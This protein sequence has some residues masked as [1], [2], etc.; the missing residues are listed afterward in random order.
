MRIA[1][2]GD[3]V[4][5]PGRKIIEANLKKIRD[6]FEIDFV[7]ANGEN[8][9]HGFGINP[10]NAN[11]LFSYGIDVITGGNHSWDKKEIIP[12]LE[13]EPRILRPDNY[14]L[15]V[16][17]SGLYVAEI[18]K[19]KLAIL[20]IMGNYFMPLVK[21]AF[22]W[23]QQRVQELKNSG[24]NS[25][26]I[27]F[28]AEVTSEKRAFFYMFKDSVSAIFGTHTHVGTDDLSIVDGCG[29]VSDIGLTGCRDNV[30]GMDIKSPLEKFLTGMPVR[31]DVPGKC[32][33]IF[34][35]VIFEIKDGKCIDAKKVRIYE[36]V[37][38]VYI[39]EAFFEN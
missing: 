9:S 1:C 33:K 29:Y 23:T 35:F 7:V 6:E 32:K 5:R 15:G 28:H 2:I 11:E 13:S 27:D 20:N 25:I 19:E 36:G 12:F 34:Q 22:R 30:I 38:Q 8:A 39:Q 14:P 37:S 10:T 17:G 18:D 16:P 3:I 21:N 4:G 31:Y 24:I 26:I